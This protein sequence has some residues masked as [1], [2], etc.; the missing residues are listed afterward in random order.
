MSLCSF[1][2][3][4]GKLSKAGF[5]VDHRPLACVGR[6]SGKHLS[7]LAISTKALR[8]PSDSVRAKRIRR[9]SESSPWS[10][11]LAKRSW[12]MLVEEGRLAG[13]S[14]HRQTAD[15]FGCSAEHWMPSDLFKPFDWPNY[16]K[17]ENPK[18]AARNQRSHHHSLN[19]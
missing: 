5:L 16:L 12:L 8:I 10:R 18:E 3:S 13:N 14:K 11:S 19:V 1:Q 4:L 15:M 7:V 9:T 2:N 17:M 6:T